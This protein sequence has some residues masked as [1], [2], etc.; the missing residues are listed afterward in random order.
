MEGRVITSFVASVDYFR[1]RETQER[2]MA[3]AATTD[4]VRDIH[5][6]LAEGYRLLAA[7]IQEHGERE[8]GASDAQPA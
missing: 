4:K 1:T 8:M 7:E 2:Q 6:T 5:L 3:D